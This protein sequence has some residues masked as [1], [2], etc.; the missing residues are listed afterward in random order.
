M[1]LIVNKYYFGR[2]PTSKLLL[3]IIVR[4]FEVIYCI[5]IVAFLQ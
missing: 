5:N 4:S 1:F 3:I 2:G